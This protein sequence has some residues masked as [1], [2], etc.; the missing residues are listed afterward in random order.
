MR[1]LFP[2]IS[3]RF[4]L[5]TAVLC[6]LALFG[7]SVMAEESRQWSDATGKFK[8]EGSFQ[9]MAGT[10]VKLKQKSGK[11]IEIELAKLSK[12][13]QDYVA[14][15]DANPFKDA[16]EG[17]NPFEASGD[18][19]AMEKEVSPKN[20]G[21]GGERTVQV[22]WD[23]ADVILVDA[24]SEWNAEVAPHPGL[25]G[26][27]KPIALPQKADFFEGLK[28]IA[29]ST[30]AK[31]AVV[32][33]VLGGSNQ[34]GG[35]RLVMCDLKTGKTAGVATGPGKMVPIALHDDGKQIVMRR[36]DFGFGNIDRLEVWTM[37]G[38]TVRKSLTWTPYDNAQNGDRDVMWAEFIDAD[39]LATSSRGG[40]IAIWE[41]ATAKPI[42]VIE[43]VVGAVPC[44]SGDRK[45]IAFNNGERFGLF[46]VADRKIVAV[47]ATPAKLQWPYM[48]F[49]PSGKRLACIAFD[50]ILVWETA[51]GK[52]LQDFQ[53]PGLHIHGA[54]G[55][56]DDNFLLGNNKYL[57]DLENRLKLWEYSG[58]EQLVTVGSQALAGLGAHNAPG[59]LLTL[60]LPH[61]GARDLLKKAL[62]D[63]DLF[64]FK[65]G[66]TVKLDVSGVPVA[67]QEYV[68]EALT[69]KLGEMDC[70]VAPEGTISVVA[71]VEGPKEREVSYFSSGDYKVQE[72]ITSLSLVYQGQP[73]WFTNSSNVPGMLWLKKGE[74]IE[75]VL[76][77]ASEKPSMGLYDSVI[78]PRFLQKPAAGQGAIGRQTL[79]ASTLTTSGLK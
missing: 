19:P 45:W 57:I 73:A 6:L 20:T 35:V 42:C 4:G 49:S 71:K 16:A 2:T 68:T 74:N 79:G 52:L 50:R 30:V 78:L 59:A 22:D 37:Q 47:E 39:H 43:T 66:T 13:D 64:V 63:P 17:D 41:F 46:S 55:F 38:K 23:Q 5:P 31:R 3:R 9:G 29:V 7:L 67:D 62:T 75:G 58:A 10:K 60:D 26:K 54:I 77:K 25:D 14:A 28:G 53:T 56:P 34:N 24:D 21:G 51:T 18:D 76:R 70:K 1:A 69:K 8:I 27:T 44:M 36:D 72:Y 65:A 40:R 61:A 11:T 32:G 15:A 33:Y 48:A 12:S